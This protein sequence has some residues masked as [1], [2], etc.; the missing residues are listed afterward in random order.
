VGVKA[1]KA[2]NSNKTHTKTLAQNGMIKT[3]ARQARK[4]NGTKRYE[5]HMPV[6]ARVCVGQP[7][8]VSAEMHNATVVHR[9]A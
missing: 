3:A 5:N 6:P 9:I 2:N 1:A 7:S 4:A 8:M